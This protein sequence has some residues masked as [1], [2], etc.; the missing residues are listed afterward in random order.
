MLSAIMLSSDVVV[1]LQYFSFQARYSRD[2]RESQIESSRCTLMNSCIIFTFSINI[3]PREQDVGVQT[4]DFL[5]RWWRYVI[6]L[7]QSVRTSIA[8]A[9]SSLL[10]IKNESLAVSEHFDRWAV[11]FFDLRYQWRSFALCASRHDE[12][13][14][15]DKVSIWLS[16]RYNVPRQLQRHDS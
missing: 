16:N 5:L 2:P 15:L 14:N 6:A 13:S 11:E 1:L 12:F 4:V 7:T 9:L 3:V 8:F 10:S